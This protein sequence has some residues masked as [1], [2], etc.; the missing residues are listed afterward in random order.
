MGSV[1]RLREKHDYYT[2]TLSFRSLFYIHERLSDSPCFHVLFT[3]GMRE[4]LKYSPRPG[5][6]RGQNIA[7]F[8]VV[9]V[10]WKKKRTERAKRRFRLGIR[11]SARCFSLPFARPPVRLPRQREIR[12]SFDTKRASDYRN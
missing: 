6:N 12:V 2:L 10:V 11:P 1:C 8:V 5:K 7:C 9:G 4:L 3:R